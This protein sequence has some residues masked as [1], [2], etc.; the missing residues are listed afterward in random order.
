MKRLLAIVICI[1]MVGI[2]GVILYTFAP[3]KIEKSVT[4][5]VY[6]DEKSQ[7]L[8]ES[9]NRDSQSQNDTDMQD[10]W[11]VVDKKSIDIDKNGDEDSIV[12]YWL[13]DESTIPKLKVAINDMEKVIELDPS[14]AFPVNSVKIKPFVMLDNKQKGIFIKLNSEGESDIHENENAPPYWFDYNFIIL[15][16]GSEGIYTIL[17]GINQSFNK[18]DNY[19]VKYK[20]DYLIQ[21]TDRATGFAAEYTATLYKSA[22]DG[23]ERLR[24]INDYPSSGISCNYFNVKVIDINSDSVDEV[25]CSKYVPGLYHADLLGVIEYTYI[26]KNGKY[27]LSKE[28]LK[29]DGESGLSVVK[30][31][32]Q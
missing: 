31:M 9:K 18:V 29:Y 28:V 21:F 26:L 25:I 1:L 10:H 23:E 32:N 6:S 7:L 14:K 20:G 13:Q 16:Y 4:G 27:Q 5:L 3:V 30:E 11:K 17:D 2:I 24:T 15:G 19:D 22:D 8:N 12:L